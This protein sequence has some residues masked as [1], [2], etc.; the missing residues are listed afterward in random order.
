MARS[1][2]LP[3]FLVILN[4]IGYFASTALIF[5]ALFDFKL[6]TEI[7]F[8]LVIFLAISFFSYVFYNE[9]KNFSLQGFANFTKYIAKH[10]LKAL[11]FMALG[12]AFIY[13][14]IYLI[15]A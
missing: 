15:I 8:Y 6:S 7:F 3:N 11:Y 2:E 14:A 4:A 9:I 13:S 5:S 1:N 12:G 10:S